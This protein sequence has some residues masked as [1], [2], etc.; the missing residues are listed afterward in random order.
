MGWGVQA[1]G[2]GFGSLWV[3]MPVEFDI[4]DHENC[5]PPQ[6]GPLSALSSDLLNHWEGGGFV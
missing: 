6:R 3:V 2:L 5:G 4:G 1:C